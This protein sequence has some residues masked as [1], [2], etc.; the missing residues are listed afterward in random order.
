MADERDTVRTIDWFEVLP[1]LNLFRALR[2]AISFRLLLLAAIAW[3]GTAAG[4]RICGQL[5]SS[6]ENERLKAQIAAQSLWPWE[7]P[8]VTQPQLESFDLQNWIEHSALYVAW[9]HLSFPFVEIFAYDASIV[10]LAYSLVCALWALVVWAFFGG[11]ITRIAAVAFARQENVSWGQVAGFV[12]PR[13]ASYFAAPLFPILGTFLAAALMALVG[14]L[15]HVEAGT[16]VAGIVWPLVL[17]GGFM[18]AFLLVGLLFGWPLMWGTISAEGTDSFGA[19]SH[20]YSYVYQ[21]PLHYLVYALVAAVIGFLGTILVVNFVALIIHLSYWG[22][23]WGA[24][25]GEVAKVAAGAEAGSLGNAGVSMIHFWNKAVGTLG[26]AFLFSYFWCAATV[27]YFLLRRQ[28][29]ATELDEVFLPEEHELR[30]L[31]PL[32]TGPDGVIEPADDGNSG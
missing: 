8:P 7:Q 20:A 10:Q 2:I 12:R 3:V 1:L 14:L 28:V 22:V 11:A 29:D 5:F 4:W 23:S 30:T 16:L 9:R 19:L 6:T 21:R 27:I 17:L 25:A 26:L 32:K 31:P 18:A 15:M 24:G 13:W